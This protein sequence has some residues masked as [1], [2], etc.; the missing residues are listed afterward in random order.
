MER[1]GWIF[2]RTLDPKLTL[3][4]GISSFEAF[5]HPEMN[6]VRQEKEQRHAETDET[7]HPINKA[8]RLEQ[9]IPIALYPGL[10]Q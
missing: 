5:V 7:A 6:H 1:K 9:E 3:R 4:A 10:R 8:H 2:Y